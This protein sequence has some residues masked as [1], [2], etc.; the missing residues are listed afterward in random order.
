MGV[1]N[2][3]WENDHVFQGVSVAGKILERRGKH[4]KA[5]EKRINRAILLEDAIDKSWYNPIEF[6]PFISIREKNQHPEKN[7]KMATWID[8]TPVQIRACIQVKKK[9]I[10]TGSDDDSSV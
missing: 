9:S 4:L 8:C 6:Y 10:V 1:F 3:S 5:R 2:F 7:F